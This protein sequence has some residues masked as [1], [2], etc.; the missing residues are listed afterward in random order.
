MNEI[1][2]SPGLMNVNTGPISTLLATTLNIGVASTYGW[3]Y[4]SATK[5]I[6]IYK[7]AKPSKATV[8]TIGN[9]T[10]TYNSANVLVKYIIGNVP[11]F[12]TFNTTTKKLSTMPVSAVAQASGTATHFIF[13]PCYTTVVDI[14]SNHITPLICGDVSITGQ[15]GDLKLNAPTLDI[16][17]GQTYTCTVDLVIP[18]NYT[19]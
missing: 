19:F 1:R 8:A 5:A 18:Y 14:T 11:N 13:F 7:G 16:V 15:A 12:T 4:Q 9:D 3:A 2:F 17:S 10:T 6:V